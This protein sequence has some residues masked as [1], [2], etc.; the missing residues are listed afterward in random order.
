MKLSHTY[1]KAE[2]VFEK[3]QFAMR[4]LG[5]YLLSMQPISKISRDHEKKIL[6]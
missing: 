2:L 5:T 1:A 6:K 4:K 3:I